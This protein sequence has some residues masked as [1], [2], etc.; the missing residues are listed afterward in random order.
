MFTNI[1]AVNSFQIN[2]SSVEVT[3]IYVNHLGESL[4]AFVL[5]SNSICCIQMPALVTNYLVASSS[6]SSNQTLPF[7]FEINQPNI[8]K[9]LWSGITRFV[10]LINILV[11]ELNWHFLIYKKKNVNRC[12]L[13]WKNENEQ[14]GWSLI[15]FLKSEL[16][17]IER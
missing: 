17:T 13:E 2:L 7:K 16:K 12:Y 5:P 9:R 10:F 1:D 4:F 11:L 6:S 3:D 14:T 8:V 15:R